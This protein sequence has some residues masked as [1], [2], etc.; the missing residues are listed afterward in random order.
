MLFIVSMT[1]MAGSTHRRS[2]SE[3][4]RVVKAAGSQ[5]LENLQEVIE[6]GKWTGFEI[7][8]LAEEGRVNKN[9]T[10]MAA[11]KGCIE[12]L[13]Y[14]VET[15]G[16]NVNVISKGEFSY[17]KTALFFASTVRRIG[18]NCQQ[19]RSNSTFDCEFSFYG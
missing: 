3:I 12:N 13:I 8:L 16:C 4:Q 6:T 14:L 9:P 18:E 5:S 7:D 17:G 11:W 19:Q 1:A 10:H 2:T 15:M